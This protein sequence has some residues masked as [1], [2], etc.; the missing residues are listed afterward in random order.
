[1]V[2]LRSL[3]PVLFVVVSACG[4]S[5]FGTAFGNPSDGGGDGSSDGSSATSDG[6]GDDGATA[7]DGGGGMPDATPRRDSG[8]NCPD[9]V[10]LYAITVV[11]GAGCGDLNPVARQCIRQNTCGILFR[12]EVPQGTIP[13]INGTANLAADGSFMN[14]TL[15]EGTVMRSG[16][17]GTWDDATSTMTVDC[18]GTGSSQSCVLSLLRTNVLC[19]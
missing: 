2:S 17:T 10:G 3:V 5:D 11:D 16:C 14:A 6:G 8:G 15:T 13:A 19:Q 12:S 9:V 1:M 4:G 7:S 18:G